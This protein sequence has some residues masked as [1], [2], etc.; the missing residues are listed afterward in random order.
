MKIHSLQ[1]GE[2]RKLYLILNGWSAAPQ[3]FE[4][5]PLRRSV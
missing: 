4:A 2:G 1:Q 3:L 5:L